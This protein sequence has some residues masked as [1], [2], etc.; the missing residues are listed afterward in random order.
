MNSKEIVKGIIR[1][2]A[3]EMLAKLWKGRG[4]FIAKIYGDGR[5][6]KILGYRV[7][8]SNG[9]VKLDLKFEE[10]VVQALS[11]RLIILHQNQILTLFSF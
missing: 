5:I 1:A 10:K 11:N 4:G 6:E 2:K 7:K 8:D 3:R 9:K